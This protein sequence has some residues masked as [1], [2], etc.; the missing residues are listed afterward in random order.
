MGMNLNMDFS[1]I[2]PNAGGRSYFPVSDSKG[3]LVV[4]TE[5]VGKENSAKT[6]SILECTLTG[7]EGPVQGKTHTL[8]I[9]ITNPS[10]KA[11]EIGLGECSAIAH[12]T[13][14]IRVGNSQEWHGK[15]FRVEIVSDASD[16]Y[17]NATRVR[18][19]LTVNGDV[20]KLPGQGAMQA[21][22]AAG[23]F[24]GNAGQAPQG[25]AGVQQG[26]GSAQPQQGQQQFQPQQQGQF[27]P[28]G[29]QQF[30]PQQGQQFQPNA[31]G[32]FQPQQGQVQ[33]QFNPQ[34]NNGGGFDPNTGQPLGAQQGQ[35]QQGQPQGGQPNWTQG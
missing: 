19:I 13:G 7:Q 24:G 32:Q 26:F 5:S 11:Q 20:P 2:E 6:G 17:P 1:N 25:T 15:P 14:H 16:Q 34:Q 18:R 30:N 9:N 33:P 35:F 28:Q 3:W 8:T 4:M 10:Q 29:G 22:A 31:G 21:G 12:A 27:N 23:N